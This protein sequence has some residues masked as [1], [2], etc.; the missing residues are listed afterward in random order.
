MKNTAKNPEVESLLKNMSAGLLPEHL[1]RNEV[2]MLE[3]RFGKDWFAE[4]GYYEPT[5]RRP[6]CM[7]P[8]RN[9]QDRARR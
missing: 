6:R 9:R 2:A 3:E 4:L 1:S 7:R 8:R 5:Y